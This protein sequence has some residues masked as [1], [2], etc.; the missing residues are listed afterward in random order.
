[1]RASWGKARIGAIAISSAVLL[2]AMLAIAQPVPA[3]TISLHGNVAPDAI[4]LSPVGHADP[5]TVLTMGITLMPRNQAEVNAL[6]AAQEDPKS[7]QYH[8]WLTTGE[9]ARRFGPT[10]QDFNAVA[11][12][13]DR[14]GFQITG[15]SQ[16]EG[17]VR[18]SG[19]VA[20]VEKAFNTKIMTFRDGSKFGN[21]TEP[22][23]PASFAPIIGEVTGLQNL[24]RLEPA[25]KSGG[26]QGLPAAR[27]SK[28][29]PPA[30][31]LISDFSPAF[32][33]TLVGG[34]GDTFAPPDFY[35]FYDENP[36]LN[37]GINGGPNPA[38]PLAPSDCIGI[39][40]Q[41]NIFTDL[42]S[43]FTS[44]QNQIFFSIAP[45]NLTIDTSAEGDP[46]VRKGSDAEAYLDIEWSH[47]VA[48]G[49]PIILYVSNPTAF[50]YEENLQDGL[51]TA[52]NQ[53]KCG[54]INISF[55]AVCGQP[56]SFFT[57]TLGTIFAKAQLQGQSVFVASGDDGVDMCN[58]GV[59]N[60]NELSA[61]PLTTSVGGTGFTPEFDGNGNDVGSVSEFAWNDNNTSNAGQNSATGGGLSQVF[62]T[63]PA[64]QTGEGAE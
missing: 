47:S 14:S 34:T 38:L 52:V 64:F 43:F 35:T 41:S 23:I 37:A 12:W 61:N 9:Y 31:K 28:I 49:D 57:S 40:A 19:S 60:V 4:A 20:T 42:L 33:M 50:T 58:E 11:A 3:Q 27:P 17:I 53:N 1:M 48:P 62:T 22:E 13:L 26:I 39:F 51:G 30:A 56:A 32:S 16:Q 15:G 2:A 7:P 21:T 24:G 44:D 29:S 18:F 8:K 5:A 63:K 54:A 45:I 25:Y 46:G 10:E 36:L 55:Q 6:I 59:P